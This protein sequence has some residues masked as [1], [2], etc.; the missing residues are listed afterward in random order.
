MLVRKM[1]LLGMCL[2]WTVLTFGCAGL[3]GKRDLDVKSPFLVGVPPP[4]AVRSV[5]GLVQAPKT[6][7]APAQASESG[8]TSA[9]TLLP[10]LRTAYFEFD[11]ARLTDETK[12]VLRQN[13]TWLR[14]NAQMEVQVQ[15][16]CCDIGTAEYNFNL[17]ARRAEAVREYLVG[18]G[19]PGNRIH[20]ISYGEERPAVQGNTEEMRRLNRRAEFHAY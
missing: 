4:P 11:S 5:P 18:L 15:G 1:F 10:A 8:A 14:S 17:G 12:E 16:H 20:T 2:G 9:S 7:A 6:P 3:W 13:A 19:I